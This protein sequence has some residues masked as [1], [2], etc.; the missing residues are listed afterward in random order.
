MG[1]EYAGET[2]KNGPQKLMKDSHRRVERVPQHPAQE[3]G[4]TLNHIHHPMGGVINISE[5]SK[6]SWAPAMGTTADSTPSFKV[7][8]GRKGA[9]MIPYSG[10]KTWRTI[11]GR[12][13]KFLETTGKSVIVLN[14]EKF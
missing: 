12:V 11:S 9:S 2:R 6:A 10:I 13:I 14:L 4:Q 5:T 3:R 1:D 8:I 7:S